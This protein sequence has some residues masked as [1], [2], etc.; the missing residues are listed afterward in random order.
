MKP[1][2]DMKRAFAAFR[3]HL[4]D[5]RRRTAPFDDADVANALNLL[6]A[7]SK[8]T[9]IGLVDEMDLFDT[10]H[11][12]V[13]LT[14]IQLADANMRRSLI[15]SG[16]AFERYRA[17][18]DGLAVAGLEITDLGWAALRHLDIVSRVR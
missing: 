14:A 6:D 7:A 10:Y 13:V 2:E 3:G 4:A 15:N 12:T 1:I 16:V 8:E 17:A 11:R 18:E 5:E 9:L